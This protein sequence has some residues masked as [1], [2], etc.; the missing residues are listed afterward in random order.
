M[1]EI[2]I[3]VAW[4]AEGVATEGERPRRGSSYVE[5]RCACITSSRIP[6]PGVELV[7]FKY[8][9]TLFVSYTLIKLEKSKF[10][11]NALSCCESSYTWGISSFSK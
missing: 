9:T 3:A 5:W 4:A 11:K 1:Q 6:N 10:L 8:L 2:R 7:H